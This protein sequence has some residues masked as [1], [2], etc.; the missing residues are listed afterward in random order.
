MNL[1]ELTP[2]EVEVLQLLIAG[3]T[4]KAIARELCITEKTVE[5]HLHNIFAK[6]GAESRTQTVMWAVQQGVR[7][8]TRDSPS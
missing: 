5:F 7:A 3:Q 6:I 2:R 8:K 1:A 4:N